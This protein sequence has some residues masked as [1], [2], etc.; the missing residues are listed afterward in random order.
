MSWR[1]KR[2]ACKEFYILFLRDSH[3]YL[4]GRFR[5]ADCQL[6]YLAN[7]NP[8]HIR[9]ALDTLPAT[10]DETYERTL[11]EIKEEKWEDARRLLLCVAVAS[12]PLQVEELAE[13][14]AFD[15]EAGSIPRFCED[16]RLQNPIEAVL[17][18]CSTLLSVVED[19]RSQVVQFAHFTVKEFLTLDRL[20]KKAT[21]FP[22]TTFP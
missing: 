16:A 4:P 10:L 22:V 19:W 21:L 18:T 1:K 9:H 14:L 13:I 7:C 6:K 17:S 2:T 11:R 20:A 15:F 3:R 5:W 12:R 8:A